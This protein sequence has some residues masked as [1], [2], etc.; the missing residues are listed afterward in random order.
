[1]NINIKN[2]YKKNTAILLFISLLLLL[3]S[4]RSNGNFQEVTD[5]DEYFLSRP[6]FI[7]ETPIS[8][9][10]YTI[11]WE[12][13]RLVRSYEI[14]MASD[15]KFTESRQNWTTKEAFLTLTEIRT[16]TVFVR[17]RSHFDGDSSRWSEILELK[18]KDDEL[19]IT[20][21]RK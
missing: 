14:Q 13:N 9:L 15:Q 20:R 2:V 1:M 10:P 3:F 7:V 4:C 8:R 17:V 6:K 16:E 18:L 19:Q 12:E 5:Q 11:K 21:V